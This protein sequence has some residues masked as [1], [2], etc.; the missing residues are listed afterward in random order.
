M[1]TTLQVAGRNLLCSAESTKNGLLIKA[2]LHEWDYL[3]IGK[4]STVQAG[5]K[6][7]K[8]FGLIRNPAGEPEV[9]AWLVA[10]QPVKLVAAKGDIPWD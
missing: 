2:D 4:G 8:V 3:G 1:T 10:P 7:M 9:W 6:I 5:N